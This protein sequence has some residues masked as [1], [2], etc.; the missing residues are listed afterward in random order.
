MFADG[1][2]FLVVVVRVDSN[3]DGD[4]LLLLPVWLIGLG[5][6]HWLGFDCLGLGLGLTLSSA[7][8]NQ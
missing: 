1:R 6:F 4:E 2:H 8:P 3:L 5:G 7:K